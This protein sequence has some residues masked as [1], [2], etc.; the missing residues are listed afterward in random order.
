M[1]PG[2][3]LM[4]IRIPG[5]TFWAARFNCSRCRASIGDNQCR[6]APQCRTNIGTLPSGNIEAA[7]G[8]SV[9]LHGPAGG[10]VSSNFVIRSG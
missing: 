8:D 2:R 4:Y 3:S 10:P 6:P 7:A 5:S 1:K 9:Y